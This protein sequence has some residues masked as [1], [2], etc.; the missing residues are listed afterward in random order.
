MI[1]LPFMCRQL[2]TFPIMITGCAHN[3]QTV[4]K[5][6]GN[7]L[8]MEYPNIG[9][10]TQLSVVVLITPD[11]AINK[12]KKRYSPCLQTLRL[13]ISKA[14]L[15]SREKIISLFSSL[16]GGNDTFSQSRNSQNIPNIPAVSLNQK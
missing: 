4:N 14:F 6:D 8:P 2:P 10:H 12:V 7:T 3:L 1:Y 16:I 15:R 11:L 9:T 5:L 13:R